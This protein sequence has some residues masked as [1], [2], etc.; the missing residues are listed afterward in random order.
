LLAP[1]ATQAKEGAD[2]YGYGSETFLSGALPPQGGY[3]LNYFNYYH[4]ELRNGSGDK[5]LIGGRV[6]SVDAVVNVLRFVEVTPHKLLG[7]QYAFHVIVPMGYQSVDIGGSDNWS[8]IGDITVDP[9]ILGLHRKNFH[10]VVAFDI[11]IPTGHYDSTNSRVSMGAHYWSFEPIYDFTY[12]APHNFEVSTKLMFN[13]PTTN[14]TTNYKSGNLFHTDFVVGKNIKSWRVG[15]AGY[16]AEQV[17]ND[18]INGREVPAVPGLWSAGRRM[19]DL[20]LGPAVAYLSPKNH[21]FLEAKYY[22]EVAVRN[23]F[24]GDRF[25]FKLVIPTAD[26]FHPKAT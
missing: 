11:N 26:L 4:G 23:H 18:S 5:V 12:M 1:L 10:S 8:G 19:Q 13:I 22:H 17:T 7:G 25:I 6:P 2:Q 15:G 3:Y 9:L 20:G 16:F 24:G 21:I 14:S